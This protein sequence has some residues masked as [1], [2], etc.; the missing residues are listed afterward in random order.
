MDTTQLENG[1]NEMSSAQTNYANNQGGSVSVAAVSQPTAEPVG[2]VTQPEQASAYSQTSEK[3]QSDEYVSWYMRTGIR[4][5]GAMKVILAVLAVIF[6]IL[7]VYTAYMHAPKILYMPI[8]GMENG[9]YWDGMAEV[10][11]P[12]MESPE[13]WGYMT[14]SGVGMF[15]AIRNRKL[16]QC[17]QQTYRDGCDRWLEFRHEI[18]M[19]N[20]LTGM[21]ALIAYILAAIVIVSW[22]QATDLPN[23]IYSSQATD[24]TRAIL[25]VAISALCG[26]L[27]AW[28]IMFFCEIA[29][30]IPML[31][32]HRHLKTRQKQSPSTIQSA[33]TKR[34]VW[35][36][37]P[38]WGMIAR[39]V[40]WLFVSLVVLPLCGMLCIGF[41]AGMTLSIV[42]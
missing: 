4:I 40:F 11:I 29:A 1:L 5:S 10:S 20:M 26:I 27:Y 6:G 24:A 13:F 3:F 34:L 22:G 17:L 16:A 37:G 18:R 42:G 36:V 30:A 25:G 31:M 2:K 39:Y 12:W 9:N 41:L 15:F 19:T 8:G 35:G 28:C 32:A 21:T 38:A 33:T 14:L 7:F 23:E